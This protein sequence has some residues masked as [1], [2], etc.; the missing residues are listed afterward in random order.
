MRKWLLSFPNPRE[1]PFFSFASFL[2]IPP[3]LGDNKRSALRRIYHMKELKVSVRDLNKLVLL[4]PGEE[5]DIINL[6]NLS[7][8][9]PSFLTNFIDEKKNAEMNRRI[10]EL[11]TQLER[12][13]E[14]SI[15]KV[16]AEYDTAL[17]KQR[18]EIKNQDLEEIESLKTRLLQLSEEKKALQEQADLRV[19]NEK[20]N[21]ESKYASELSKAK[22]EIQALMLEK[23]ALEDQV[24]LQI[25]KEKKAVEAD[26]SS[27]LASSKAEYD[28]LLEKNK[29]LAY[30]KE[31][32]LKELSERLEA[33]KKNELETFLAKKEAENS[34]REAEVKEQIQALT[35]QVQNAEVAKAAALQ[36]LENQHQ[37]EKLQIQEEKTKEI[38]ELE[39]KK[40]KELQAEKDR[41]D[42]LQ[43]QYNDIYRSKS[44]LNM[45]VIGENLESWCDD[46]FRQA[47]SLGAFANTVWEKDNTCVKEEGESGYG[48]KADYI[49]RS[50]SDSD[51]RIEIASACLD[52]KSENPD[53]VNKKK[54]SDY[55]KKLDSD[56]KKKNCE[57]AILVSELELRSD[58]D[59][60]VY[61]VQEYQNMY[62]VRPSYFISFLG[63]LY[64][65]GVK[66]A[67]LIESKQKED[68]KFKTKQEILE[69][70]EGYKVT[71]LEKPIAA[72]EKQARDIIKDADNVI[73]SGTSIRESAEK[74]AEIQI[75]SMKSKIEKLTIN[76]GKIG[77]KIEKQIND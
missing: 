22:Q 31:K 19:E 41:Y 68:E 33:E 16:K 18:E 1:K 72:I 25:E 24:A 14:D 21:V 45:K 49:F 38:A 43:K 7:Q 73:K 46:A 48:T 64:T 71:Y 15:S 28:S 70:F 75:A 58:N 50:Y 63:V 17:L 52:M 30:Q 29:A 8:I 61:K 62:V 11:R 40:Q 2:A 27:K 74:I 4:E 59:V 6:S 3:L 67:N 32:E 12:Q 55:F 34:K 51:H 13:Q 35:L 39:E 9:D 60:P 10:Q 56:R 66:F 53:S 42:V 65:L 54:N 44:S 5:G 57:Y 36:A 26:Y 37:Q 23:K 69:E 76:L 47:Q 20:N 77:N